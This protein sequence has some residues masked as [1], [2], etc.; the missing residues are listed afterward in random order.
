MYPN[1]PPEVRLIIWQTLLHYRKTLSTDGMWE[2]DRTLG[3]PLSLSS[4]YFGYG[5]RI[6]REL[7]VN[8]LRL[9]SSA[10]K[11]EFGEAFLSSHTFRFNDAED[12]SSFLNRLQDALKAR[13]RSIDLGICPL[14]YLKPWLG[15]VTQLPPELLHI[16]F[17]LYPA[18]NTPDTEARIRD[19]LEFLEELVRTA[20]K[21]APQAKVSICSTIQAPLQPTFQA[22]ADAIT[23]RLQRSS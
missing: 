16:R 5:R 1:R 19:S 7:N 3:S 2:Y 6:H 15:P 4:Y 10:I 22:A 11:L 23:D 8:A 20:A 21:A 17:R 14:Y 12:L 9:V 13:V 18:I